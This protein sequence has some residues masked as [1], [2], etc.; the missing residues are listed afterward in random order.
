M[1]SARRKYSAESGGASAITFVLFY[2]NSYFG[3]GEFLSATM[4]QGLASLLSSPSSRTV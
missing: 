1:L 2:D 3:D 4:I